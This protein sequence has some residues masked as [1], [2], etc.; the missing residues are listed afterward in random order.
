MEEVDSRKPERLWER[1]WSGSG[2]IQ[3][4]D[5]NKSSGSDEAQDIV[6][7]YR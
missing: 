7:P 6:T 3:F 5:V 1:T 4:E 2:F